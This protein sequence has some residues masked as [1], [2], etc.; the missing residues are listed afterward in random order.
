MV[1]VLLKPHIGTSLKRKVEIDL[2]QDMIFCDGEHVGYVGRKPTSP[3]CLIEHGLPEA[4]KDAIHAAVK[5][6]YGGEQVKIA[7]PV[8]LP[9]GFG[10]ETEDEDE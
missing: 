3:I 4:K 2:N 9:E 7:E 10:E 5:A 8:P 6:K 1:Q